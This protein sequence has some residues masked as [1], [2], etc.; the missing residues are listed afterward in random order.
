MRENAAA[1]ARRYLGESRVVLTQVTLQLPRLVPQ[2][3]RFRVGVLL[4]LVAEP[5]SFPVEQ[6][7]PAR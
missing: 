1:K 2:L 3:T 6:G 5:G 7:K 4:E